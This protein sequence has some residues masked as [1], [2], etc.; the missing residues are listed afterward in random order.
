LSRFGSLKN[1]DDIL[2]SSE[3]APA[4]SADENYV[5]DAEKVVIG[6]TSGTNTGDE[7]AA[8]IATI[9]TGAG[10]IT[11]PL[12]AD[13][14]P[15]YKIV[16]TLLKKVTWANIK[17]TLKTYFDTLYQVVG[18]YLT[19]AN[20]SDTVYGA[21]WNGVTTI[22]PSKNA[23]YDQIGLLVT[24]I[25]ARELLYTDVYIDGN[26]PDL[27][28]STNCWIGQTAASAPSIIFYNVT[29]AGITVYVKVITI[30]ALGSVTLDFQDLLNGTDANP[31]LLV[32]NNGAAYMF[33]HNGTYWY[34]LSP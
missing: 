10:A 31:V 18:S 13:E 28:G 29:T 6:N 34:Q 7:T 27:T 1:N 8:R 19:S 12:D 14:F 2:L 4:L 17:A 9:I 24:D 32:G 16:G 5:T 33:K 30:N 11:E 25:E 23:V 15:F 21:G 26:S 22:A 20:I 3:A